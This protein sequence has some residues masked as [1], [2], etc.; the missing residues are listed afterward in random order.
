MGIIC[1]S[2]IIR[3]T[4]LNSF[5]S[6]KS[7]ARFLSFDKHLMDNE[8]EVPE[9]PK[10]SPPVYIQRYETMVK[11]INQG[12]YRKVSNTKPSMSENLHSLATMKLSETRYSQ[13]Q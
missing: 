6:L 13:L 7:A 10:F 12:D 1:P 2:I 4:R 9:G 5:E 8:E 11:L 3:P